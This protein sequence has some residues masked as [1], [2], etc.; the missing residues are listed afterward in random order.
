MIKWNEK[1]QYIISDVDD[2]IAPVYSNISSRMVLK[3]EA[4]LK[5]NIK[6][7]LISG[8]SVSNIVARVTSFIKPYLRKNIYICH[9]N[10]AEIYEFSEQG[11]LIEKPLFSILES[12]N[13][14]MRKLWIIM[15]EIQKHFGLEYVFT[16]KLG[17]FK[18]YA[19]DSLKYVMVENRK[20]QISMD[21]VNGTSSMNDLNTDI[22]IRIA[23]FAKELLNIHKLAIE[24]KL[25]GVC[26]I[27][28]SMKGVDKGLAVRRLFTASDNKDERLDGQILLNSSQEIEIWGDSFSKVNGDSDFPMCSAL[29]KDVRTICFRQCNDYRRDYNIQIWDGKMLSEGLF[30]YLN[31]RQVK[32]LAYHLVYEK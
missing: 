22:R 3:L 15:R 26:A 18:V 31:S 5:E 24:P 19:G 11:I 17:E 29:P 16:S 8:Q 2:T 27:D 28:F 7:V 4:L 6:L 30:E 12:V 10:G 23:K 25:A 21:F 14:D 13:I 9:C 32:Q 1:V 20:V